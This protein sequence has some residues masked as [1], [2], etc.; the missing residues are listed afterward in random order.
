MACQGGGV[1]PGN[2]SGGQSEDPDLQHDVRGG[3]NA[4]FQQPGHAWP[5]R[6]QRDEP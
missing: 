1:Q 2:Q 4:E 5:I 6:R 3:G